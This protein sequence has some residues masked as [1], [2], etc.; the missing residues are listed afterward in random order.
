MP[1]TILV[2]SFNRPYYLDRCLRSIQ[3]CL[4]GEYE[5]VVLDDGTPPAYLD[6]IRRRYPAVR[7]EL[8]E[9]YE[10]KV[11]QIEAHAAGGPAFSLR[12]IPTKLWRKGVEQASAV[13]CM[14]EDD[15]WVT[16]PFDLDAATAYMRERQI[17]LTK[18]YWGG[19]P[20]SFEGKLAEAGPDLREYRPALPKGPEWFT[21][22]VLLNQFKAHSILHRLRLVPE[23]IYY[24]L[25]FY[26]L[27]SVASALFDR[28]FWLHLWPATQQRADE[29]HQL[30]RALNW[31][32]RRPSRFAKTEQEI[33]QT[34]FI[35]SATNG[36]PGVEFDVFAFNHYLNQAWLRGEFD[37]MQ[38]YPRDFTPEYLGPVL[39]RAADPRCT[40]ANWL[41]WIE[42]FKQ[43]YASMGVVVE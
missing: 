32:K 15:I 6:E 5:V 35:T 4:R 19:D 26:G 17:V 40:F 1:V 2:K 31:T 10:A 25:P 24:Q 22:L 8:S 23:G 37:A 29:V 36:F 21:R 16:R 43:V 20:S 39:D 34:S 18:M 30:A 33:T 41:R 27:Y 11:A 9:A 28:E 3:E 7:I 14:L 13:V 42:H 38:A 12:N